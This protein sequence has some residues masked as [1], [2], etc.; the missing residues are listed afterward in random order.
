MKLSLLLIISIPAFSQSPQLSVP[1]LERSVAQLAERA[2]DMDEAHWRKLS[3]EERTRVLQLR[4]M[5]A[6]ARE[7]WESARRGGSSAPEM[8]TARHDLYIVSVTLLA[9]EDEWRRLESRIENARSFTSAD[10]AANQRLLDA[11]TQDLAA[12][13]ASSDASADT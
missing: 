9:S 4:G 6:I 8:E 5:A 3:D 7:S 12:A 1:A 10:R 2:L 13:K 11:A